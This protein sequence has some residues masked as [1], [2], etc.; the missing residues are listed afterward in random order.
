MFKRSSF[1]ILP[2]LFSLQLA[3]SQNSNMQRLNISKDWKF[4]QVDK[5]QWWPAE[6]PGTVHTD[7]LAK[8]IIEDPYYRTNEKD[9]QWIDKEDW[10]YATT[11]SVREQLLAKDHLHLQFHG[12]DTYADVYL[13]GQLILKAHNFFRLWE[14]DVKKYLQSDSNELRLYFHSPIKVGLEKLE[15]HGYGLPAINDQSKNGGLGK[16]KVSVFTRKPGY[17]YGWDWGPR[18]VTSGIWRPI[19]LLA[20]DDLRMNDLYFH[21]NTV[22]TQLAEI[23]ARFEIYSDTIREVMLEIWQDSHLLKSQK[24]QLLE[25]MNRPAIPIRIEQPKLWW[26]KE[27]GEPHLYAMQG[28]VR[29]SEK[30]IAK[31]ERRIGLRNIRVLQIPDEQGRSFYLELNGVPV[32]SKGAN[33]IPNDLF[34]PRVSKAHYEKA[35]QS[36]VDANMNMLRIWG[37]GI[38]END[39]FYELCDEQGIMVWQDFMFACSM[40]PGNEAFLEDV[41]QEAI[42]NVRRL[43]NHACIALWC[44]NN[45]MDVAWAQ[46][47][48]FWGWGWKQRYGGTKRKAI[49][50]A[51]EDVFHDI[52]PEVV[53]T[54][55]PGMFYWPS[56]P[57][58]GEKEHS[59][60]NATSGDIHYWGVWHG[61]EPFKAFY[62]Y[63]GRF[64][65]E[66]GFQS[67]PAFETVK[68]YTL[69][70]DWD[71]ES[72][73]MAAHQRSGIGNLRIRTYMN[74]YYKV[75]EAFKDQLYIGQLLQAEG[76]KMAIEAHRSA[77]P[78]CMGSLYWQL[79]DCWPVASWSG[80]DYYQNW[81]AMHYFVKKA[82]APILLAAKRDDDFIELTAVNDLLD[83]MEATLK[84]SIY[85]FDG[86]LKQE[87]TPKQITIPANNS[88]PLG[89]WEIKNFVKKR[90]RDDVFMHAELVQD[91][92]VIAEQI[93]YFEEVK[94]LKL[95]KEFDLEQRVEKQHDHYLIHL[96]SDHLLKNVYLQFEGIEGFFS[97]NYFDVL[98]NKSYVIQFMPTQPDLALSIKDMSITTVVDTY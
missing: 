21:Q 37:G 7:L 13:N 9:Q 34:L 47:K 49:W 53:E 85:D 75:P 80:M 43:R 42:D 76:I 1:L 65:S 22:N 92:T 24:V 57:M 8:G 87:Q 30:V 95:P 48:E 83:V 71:I 31:K 93:V 41:R 35:I 86:N 16:K 20:W 61:K 14:V 90:N 73:V 4:R 51:Y 88:I 23:E 84:V 74:D 27:L 98:P 66:Y 91:D 11:F 44:G 40:Y 67:F 29:E 70:E 69:P 32:F 55:H 50:K 17:H 45:E 62:K 79:N 77:K 56:S 26:T 33:Y 19:E 81:K 59:S 72:E 89:R 6:V 15:E 58:A 96:Y 97:D 2:F 10:E 12:L 64:M 38:Y 68:K 28:I 3:I 46:Y 60:K 78:Y 39:V 18:F 25:G 52:L 82:Y 5:D 54:H 94:K 63:I 36:A